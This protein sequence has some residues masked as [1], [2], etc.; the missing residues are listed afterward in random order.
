M[1]NNVVVDILPPPI[2]FF[3][4]IYKLEDSVKYLKRE[5]NEKVFLGVQINIELV[6]KFCI[7]SF[8]IRVARHAKSTQNFQITQKF[9]Y[10]CNISRNVRVF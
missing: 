4:P 8:W 1:K 9:A 7:L 3:R 6:C 10:L 2:V 5:V